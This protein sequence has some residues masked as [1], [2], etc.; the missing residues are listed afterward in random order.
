MKEIL[1]EENQKGL[2]PVLTAALAFV[3]IVEAIALMMAAGEGES[4]LVP[5][6]ISASVTVILAAALAIFH[7]MTIRLDSQTLRFG[8]APFVVKVPLEKITRVAVAKYGIGKTWGL[9]IRLTFG[10]RFVYNTFW[11]DAIEVDWAGRKHAFSI[12]EPEKF[13]AELG[14]LRP[15]LL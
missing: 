1:F 13:M 6:I 4:I 9:G 15:E 12:H 14:K 8:F 2:M 3:T 5:L 11:G 7:K 10:G